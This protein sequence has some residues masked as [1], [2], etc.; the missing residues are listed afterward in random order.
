LAVKLFVYFAQ[1]NFCYVT[2][3]LNC[4]IIK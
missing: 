1:V 3:V 2:F 4:L